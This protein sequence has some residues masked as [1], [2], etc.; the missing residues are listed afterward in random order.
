MEE[1][2]AEKLMIHFP[3]SS[4]L[5]EVIEISPDGQRTLEYLIKTLIA[6]GLAVVTLPDNQEEDQH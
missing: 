2:M 6:Q 1:V 4:N 5:P 3:H